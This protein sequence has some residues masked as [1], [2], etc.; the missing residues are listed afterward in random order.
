MSRHTCCRLLWN[1]LCRVGEADSETVTVQLDEYWREKEMKARETE[2]IFVKYSL[3]K[4]SLMWG[5]KSTTQR[6]W[7]ILLTQTVSRVHIILTSFNSSVFTLTFEGF[8]HH[9]S[10]LKSYVI[11]CS[12]LQVK[13]WDLRIWCS[14]SLS[15]CTRCWRTT[16]SRAR[17]RKPCPNSST[18][19]SCTCR[20]LRIRWGCLYSS[21]KHSVCL[22]W[23]SGVRSDCLSS[24]F[25]RSK[26][27]QLT[28]SSL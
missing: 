13:F 5:Q 25:F 27:G 9:S 3:T 4:C 14:A 28:R 24:C 16:S 23:F 7:M 22:W 10:F 21:S 1:K 2:N 26:C 19:S 15:L 18:T 11:I 6:K 17:W 12:F 8:Y 20:S